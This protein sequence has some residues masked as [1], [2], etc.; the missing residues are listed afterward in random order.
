MVRVQ[1][2]VNAIYKCPYVLSQLMDVT[3]I[4]ASAARRVNNASHNPDDN[5]AAVAGP[6]T[7]LALIRHTASSDIL[8][9]TMFKGLGNHPAQLKYQVKI[10]QVCGRTCADAVETGSKVLPGAS[11]QPFL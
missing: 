8:N 11:V 1:H 10:V 7:K 9:H 5:K 3:A 2:F 4:S 6:T